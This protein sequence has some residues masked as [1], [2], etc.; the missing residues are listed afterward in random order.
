MA[1]DNHPEALF[2]HGLENIAETLMLDHSHSQENEHHE[3]HC[4]HSSAHSLAIPNDYL[5]S[6]NV[7]QQQR[8]SFVKT[9]T[10]LPFLPPF[11]RP[12]TA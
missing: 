6:N 7:I 8:Q 4:C 9:N 10:P 12:P 11:L 5:I 3:D 1:W 2:G